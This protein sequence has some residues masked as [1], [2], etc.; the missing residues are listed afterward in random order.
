MPS[1]LPNT[2]ASAVAANGA[3]D[4][5][6]SSRSVLRGEGSGD[7]LVSYLAPNFSSQYGHVLLGEL[8]LKDVAGKA[9]D[10]ILKANRY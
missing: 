7:W 10:L 1:Q 5:S 2:F 6:S 8:H 4:T 3:N 9:N